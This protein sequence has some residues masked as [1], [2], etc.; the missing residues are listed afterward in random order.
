VHVTVQADQVVVLQRCYSGVTVVLQCC[1]SGYIV[2]TLWFNCYT[3]VTLY[4]PQDVVRA[5]VHVTV[6]AD[7]VV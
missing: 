7:Q 1:Y 3:I 2:F 6:Q 4:L 5:L